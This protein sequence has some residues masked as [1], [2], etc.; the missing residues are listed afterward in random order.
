M[1]ASSRFSLDEGGPFD[2]NRAR[3]K[4]RGTQ[5]GRKMKIVEKSRH[6]SGLMAQAVFSV[7]RSDGGKLDRPVRDQIDREE[8][9]SVM[10]SL[11]NSGQAS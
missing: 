1:L 5:K 6:C 11:P 9:T 10:A 2:F 7:I 4:H 3:G 8:A